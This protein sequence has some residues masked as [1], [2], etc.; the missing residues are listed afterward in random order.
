MAFSTEVKDELAHIALTRACCQRAE[1]AAIVK[2][3]GTLHLRDGEYELEVATA[4]AAA[5]RVVV[6]GL[7]KLYGLSTQ[8][9]ARRSLLK[10]QTNEYLVAIEEQ[11]RLAQALNDL[12][13]IDDRSRIIYGILPRLVRQKCDAVAFLRGAFLAGGFV[14]HPTTNAHLE[15]TTP[16]DELAQ[17]LAALAHRLGV[18]A[19]LSRRRNLYAVYVKGN[20]QV[21][22]FLATV[23]AYRALLALEEGAVLKEVRADVNRLVNCDTANVAK[24]VAAATAQVEAIDALRLAGRLDQLGPALSAVAEA[25]LAHP[26]ASLVE[27]GDLMEP[28]LSKSAVYHRLRRLEALAADLVAGPS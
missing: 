9:L 27:L 16:T 17:D 2:V 26:E 3:D 5:A 15:L 28:P 14:A 19:K 24:A 12:G 23:G 4:S 11:T 8:V 7:H 18:E 25:R 22:R 1:L 13:I 21:A 6:E 20:E 10:R